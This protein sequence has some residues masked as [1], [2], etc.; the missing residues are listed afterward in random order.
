MHCFLSLAFFQTLFTHRC[1]Y[2]SRI[3]SLKSGCARF[4]NATVKVRARLGTH[5]GHASP[6]TSQQGWAIPGTVRSEV[7]CGALAVS[8]CKG[9]EGQILYMVASP[10][11]PA[12]VPPVVPYCSYHRALDAPHTARPLQCLTSHPHSHLSTHTCHSLAQ[13]APPHSLGADSSS[14]Y[15]SNWPFLCH[16]RPTAASPVSPDLGPYLPLSTG[17]FVFPA[18][19]I[20]SNLIFFL[21]ILSLP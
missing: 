5:P 10:P 9:I 19:T 7:I 1:V 17:H 8:S 14:K 21:N 4:C 6:H 3:R 15:S 13:C 2:S 16:H 12:S 11:F 18:I 20:L